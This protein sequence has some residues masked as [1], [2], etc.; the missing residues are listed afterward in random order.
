MNVAMMQPVALP[1]QGLFELI[2]KSDI[3]IFLDDFQFSTQ[4]WDQRNRF[5]VNKGQVGWY[6]IPVKKSVSFLS[7]FNDV[8]I[9]EAGSWRVKMGKRVQQNYA[10][11]SFY[12]TVFPVLEEWL[13][14]ELESLASQNIAFIEAVCNLLGLK[15]TFL[16]SSGYPADEKRSARVL[17]LLRSCGATR[18]YCAKGSFGYMLAD[19]LFPVDD[20]EVLF[21]DFRHSPYPQIGSPDAFVPYLSIVDA[22]MNAGPERTLAFITGGTLHWW[23]WREMHDGFARGDAPCGEEVA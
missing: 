3:F 5:F 17:Q 4:S 6:T 8:K 2:F 18:Y 23:T 21:Q 11:A 19:G 7:P 20:V 13:S 9:N 15:R 22:L 12:R 10:K 1:W 16:L 14:A